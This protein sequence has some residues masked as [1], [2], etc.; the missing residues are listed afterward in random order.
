[1]EFPHGGA[2]GLGA[3]AATDLGNFRGRGN[4]SLSVSATLESDLSLCPKSAKV[5]LKNATVL[6]FL[7]F[8][9]P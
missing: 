5:R 3:R 8:D 7:S 6:A 2:V 9:M 1:L 4:H